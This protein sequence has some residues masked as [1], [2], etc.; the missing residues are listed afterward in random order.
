MIV[1]DQQQGQFEGFGAHLGVTL[2]DVPLASFA[3]NDAVPF[4]AHWALVLGPLANGWL[5][6]EVDEVRH[7]GVVSHEGD[8]V[9]CW[10]AAAGHTHDVT[11]AAGGEKGGRSNGGNDELTHAIPLRVSVVPQWGSGQLWVT[12]ASC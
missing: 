9:V 12:V 7:H 2:L 6:V 11:G 3:A 5:L 10:A 1:Y 8:V 4:F